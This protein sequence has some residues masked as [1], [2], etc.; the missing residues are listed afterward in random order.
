MLYL[1][2]CSILP[3]EI[4]YISC[5]YYSSILTISTMHYHRYMSY[6]VMGISVMIF[7][8][9][10]LRNFPK[11][12]FAT[13]SW[14]GIIYRHHPWSWTWYTCWHILLLFLVKRAVYLPKD[15]FDTFFWFILSVLK[16]LLV[17]ITCIPKYFLY[18]YLVPFQVYCL[19]SFLKWYLQYLLLTCA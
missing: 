4:H 3:A 8:T 17:T 11:D 10:F 2:Y 1:K 7:H 14:S 9:V 16:S 6:V 18:S 12:I 19:Q 13:F 5:V 15:I